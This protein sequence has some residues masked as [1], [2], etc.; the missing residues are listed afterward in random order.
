MIKAD[1]NWLS[2]VL[3]VAPTHPKGCQLIDSTASIDEISTD[4]RH[5]KQGQVFLA[6]KG[7][8]FDGSKFVADV[9]KKGAIAVIVEQAVE[10]DIVQFVVPDTLKA[11]GQIGRAVAKTVNTPNIAMTGSVGKTS[12]KEMC[13]AIMSQKGQVLATNGNFNNE[14]GVPLTLLRFEEHH[15]YGVIELGANHIGEIDYTSSLV[16]PDVAILNNVAPSHLEGFGSL[17]GI[18]RAKGEIFNHLKEGGTAIINAN[19][20]A[21]HRAYWFNNL[22]EQFATRPGKVVLF[23]ADVALNTATELDAA[24]A[25]SGNKSG[26]NPGINSG[27]S[28]EQVVFATNVSLDE[29]ACARFTLNVR[30]QGREDL[31]QIDIQLTVPG[32]HNVSNALAACAAC[33]QV[34]ASLQDVKLGLAA[35][36]VVQGRVNLKPINDHLMLIDDSYNANVQSVKAAIDL[37]SN[38]KTHQML[39]L[40]DM[41]ELG[42]DAEFYH[43]EVGQYAQQKGI[44]QLFT[45]GELSASATTAF[46]QNSQ[47]EKT[48]QSSAYFSSREELVTELNKQITRVN[49]TTSPEVTV[50]VKGSRSAQMELVIEQVTAL[51]TDA[52]KNK[53]R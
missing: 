5:I 19:A 35:M 39:V 47:Q 13:A 27:I 34:G 48:T 37:L 32:E 2:N 16:E 7:P 24:S 33:M 36:K 8:S 23:G 28:P 30:T 22:A 12:V 41:G 18:V 40:G 20:E 38:Y 43:Q 3:A 6:L 29:M 21:E 11:L 31:E 42:D 9:I 46:N 45:L 53:G 50:L 44:Q 25:N 14:I 49:G 4:S 52:D 10:Q 51:R 15:D 26:A 1:L 17:D